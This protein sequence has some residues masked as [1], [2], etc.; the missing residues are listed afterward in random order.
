[1]AI[2]T[3]STITLTD[4]PPPSPVVTLSG[5]WTLS[6]VLIFIILV[7]LGITMRLNQADI[8]QLPPNLFYALM[9]LHGLGM[10]GTLLASGLVFVWYLLSTHGVAPH[11]GWMWTSYLLA[12]LGTVGVVIATL[13]GQFGAGWYLLYPLPFVIPT[14]PGW[15]AGLAFVSLITM[16]VSWLIA[17]VVLLLSMARH[18]GAGN[19]LG[20][21]YFK[22][23]DPAEIPP[24]VLIT[25]VSVLAGIVGTVAG[26]IFLLMN[27]AQWGDL[28]G[29][30][31]VLLMKNI[32]FL[33]GHTIVN[34]TMY[35][36][37]AGVYEVMPRFSGR[38]WYTNKAVVV[39]WN[40]ALIFVLGAYFHHLYMDFAQ[41]RTFQYLGQI[42]SY[43]SSVPATVVTVFGMIGQVFH[44][45]LKWRVVPLTF[46][47]AVV[48]WVIGGFA[49]V[50]DSTIG[51]NVVFHNTLWVPAHFHTYFLMG[52]LLIV[53]GFIYGQ[54]HAVAERIAK[55]ALVIMLAGGY[56]FLAMFYTGGVFGVPRRY[57][58]YAAIPV[59][60]LSDVASHLAL[61][62][63][64]A[65]MV[66]L[67]GFFIYLVALAV[68]SER[69]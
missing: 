51:V 53:L 45:G 68:R 24:L 6:I 62:G 41:P 12:M 59:K 2:D 23:G 40:C 10:A 57:A 29:G 13:V 18:Y 1:M 15:A 8:A 28:D 66:F 21:Q 65:A 33:F 43:S 20:W 14:W 9:T 7:L 32:V 11:T 37:I 31:N 69:A 67:S 19:L 30:Y 39:S 63:A 64:I 47:L 22:A 16:G 54:F 60:S 49:A 26:A 27:L 48:G 34:I 3:D 36:G 61:V 55:A 44:S 35:L 42:F 25:T 17:Q 50:I 56:T 4:T 38:A 58:S 46:F 52:Y 5:V